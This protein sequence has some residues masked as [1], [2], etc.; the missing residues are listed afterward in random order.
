MTNRPYMESSYNTSYSSATP[1]EQAS[2]GLMSQAKALNRI[3]NLLNG[4]GIRSR[5]QRRSRRN[6][7]GGGMQVRIK[8]L[9]EDQQ[10]IE[11]PDNATGRSVKEWI[12]E[13][14][15]ID[16][17]HQRIISVQGNKVLKDDTRL[18]SDQRFLNLKES[19]NIDEVGHV[20]GGR[21]LDIPLPTDPFTMPGPSYNNAWY[22]GEP[23]VGNHCGVPITP[24]V[25]EYIHTALDSTTP[26]AN[27]QY[28]L[29]D[30][31]GNSLGENLPGI[32]PY[33]GTELNSG[34]FAFN[35]VSGGGKKQ[36]RSRNKQRRSRARQY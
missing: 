18:N 23:C 2:Q 21:T 9:G 30:R 25:S 36:K 16:P 35:C 22:T 10:I 20:G 32:Q 27:T 28:P 5:K 11:M 29:I 31:L 1:S 14:Y 8:L 3:N 17:R 26:G 24:Y 33:Q 6:Q 15:G 13:N 12:H 7:N 19:I 34:P 4:G